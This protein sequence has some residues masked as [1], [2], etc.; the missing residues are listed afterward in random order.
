MEWT[1][2]LIAPFHFAD[3]DLRGAYVAKGQHQRRHEGGYESE[4]AAPALGHTPV[5]RRDHAAR[6]GR[7]EIA[8]R[9]RGRSGHREDDQATPRLH[10]HIP[11]AQPYTPRPPP[12]LHIEPPPR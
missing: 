9:S 5:A 11:G 12:Y 2:P 7:E 6:S 1:E 10:P 3:P 4:G 8:G